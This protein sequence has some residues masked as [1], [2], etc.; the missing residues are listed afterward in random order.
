[1]ILPIR[2]IGRRKQA[3][4]VHVEVLGAILVMSSEQ[5]HAA[6][7]QN[8]RWVGRIDGLDDRI[9]GSGDLDIAKKRA[10]E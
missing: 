5:V 7:V 4:I 1:M 6:I 8:G 10:K 3:P 2:H 9:V